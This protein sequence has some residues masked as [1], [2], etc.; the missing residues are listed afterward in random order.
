MPELTSNELNLCYNGLDRLSKLFHH[1]LDSL[2]SNF[3]FAFPQKYCDNECPAVFVTEMVKKPRCRLLVDNGELA[4]D[5]V[6]IFSSLKPTSF[7]F[8]FLSTIPDVSAEEKYFF[9]SHNVL[10]VFIAFFS[11]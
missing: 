11:H 6:Q 10:V 9:P 4:D 3:A 1:F 2:R 5:I 7:C 8:S